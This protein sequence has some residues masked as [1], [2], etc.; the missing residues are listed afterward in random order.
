[1]TA[2][3]SRE[4]RRRLGHCGIRPVAPLLVVRTTA[5]RSSGMRPAAQRR[6]PVQTARP[7][8]VRRRWRGVAVGPAPSGMDD[9]SE[10]DRD[11]TAAARS[12]PGGGAAT[13]ARADCGVGRRRGGFAAKGRHDRQGLPGA[14]AAAGGGHRK[15]GG[16]EVLL[17]VYGEG[18][19]VFFDRE[20]ELCGVHTHNLAFKPLVGYIKHT[21]VMLVGPTPGRVYCLITEEA[22]FVIRS[23]LK[24]LYFLHKRGKCPQNFNESNVFIREDGMVQLRGCYLDDKSDSLVFKNYKDASNIIEK[25]L[26]GQHKEDIPEDVMHLLN[27]MNTQDKVF[28]MDL[29]YLI[30]TH[31]SLVPLR[32][33]ET[34][35]LWMYTHIMFVLPYDK[36]TERNEIINAL[37]KVDWRDTLQE[38]SVLGKIFWRKRDGSEEEIDYFLHCYRDTVFHGTDKYN[39]KG[40]RY[41]PDDIQLI[42]WVTF[43]ML[44]PTMQQEL[45]NK[46]QWRALKLDG[47]LGSTMEDVFDVTSCFRWQ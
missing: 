19:D 38:D 5:A 2:A 28:S 44:L 13:A 41:T 37:Q 23:L 24:E 1:M 30:C 34:F 6:R 3:R 7:S 21:P 27:L 32:N 35:F 31:A 12:I 40:K 4:M 43:P 47:L 36:S 11:V 9:D 20:T 15:G 16:E 14:V 10:V 8:G 17:R 29:E 39:A 42:L 22:K 18:V 45:W 46:N 33:R 25:I 26:F